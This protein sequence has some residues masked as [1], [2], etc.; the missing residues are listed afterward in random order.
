MGA[1][2]APV[3]YWKLDGNSQDSAGTNNGSNT[4]INYSTNQGVVN[5]GAAFNGTSSH[6]DIAGPLSGMVNTS[7]SAWIKT[8][9][10]SAT[11]FIASQR[12]SDNSTGQWIFYL[13]HGRLVFSAENGG[14]GNGGEGNS[15]SI[16]DG[17]WHHVGVSQSGNFYTFYLDG[18]ADGTV[19]QV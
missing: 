2:S 17:N 15:N 3:A 13:D 8:S 10:A 19:T 12:D 18:V 5:Q 14:Q 9:A 6:I 4:N 1:R 7:V 11:M 16:A